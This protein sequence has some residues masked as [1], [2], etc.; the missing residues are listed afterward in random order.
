[1]ISQTRSGP[2]VDHPLHRH[3]VPPGTHR[4]SSCRRHP[5]AGAVPHKSA[6]IRCDGLFGEFYILCL[7]LK[8]TPSVSQSIRLSNTLSV[9]YLCLPLPACLYL[10]A[11][12]CLPLP[13]CLYLPATACLPSPPLRL[14]ASTS[15]ASTRRSRVLIRLRS[16][17]VIVMGSCCVG[18]IA[19]ISTVPFP[20]SDY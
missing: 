4:N 14:F 7:P 16:S 1:M 3:R 9:Y 18:G 13:A 6:R 8:T 10:P 5:I 12:T 19:G 17:C 2:R 20:P 11:S 15:A